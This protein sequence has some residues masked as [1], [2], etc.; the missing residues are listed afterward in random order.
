MLALYIILGILLFLFLVSLFNIWIYFLYDE[1]PELVIRIAFVKLRLL[2]PKP[3]KEKKAEKPKK[4]KKKKPE[5]KEKKKEK[6]FDFKAYLKQKGVS[7][8]LNITKRAAKIVAGTLKGLFRHF[9]VPQLTVKLVISGE[10]SA[11]A[12]VMYGRVCTVFF[13]AIRLITEIVQVAEYDVSVDP[14]FHAD[15]VS[16]AYAK[17]T[18]RIRIIF[19]LTTVLSKAFA[20]LMLYIK[21]KPKKVKKKKDKQIG[22]KL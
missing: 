2:P 15:A 16:K 11:D 19:I 18:A 9:H 1:E 21:A 3:E 7:G 12:G 5:K 17:V 8:L 22:E 20:A 13:P 10:D 4:Q 6:T 14:D